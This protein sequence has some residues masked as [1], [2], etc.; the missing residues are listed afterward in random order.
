MSLKTEAKNVGV[1]LRAAP[2]PTGRVHIGNLRTFFYNYLYVKNQGGSFILRIEDTDQT[3]KVE[4]GTEGI[5]ETLKLYGIT[6]DEGPMSGGDYGPYVQ[7]QRV[8][9]YRKYAEELVEKG[10]AYYCFCSAD[11]LKKLREE[12]Q[13]S[14]LKPRYDRKCRNIDPQEAKKRVEAGESYVIRMKAPLEG[15]TAFEDVVYG[16]ITTPNKEVGD[17]ILLKSDGYPT[18]HLGVVV[19]DHLMEVSHIMRS[20]EWLPS[21]PKHIVMYE[22]FGWKPPIYVHVPVILNPE[23]PGKLS[24]RKGAWPAISYLRKGYLKEAVLNYFS[25]VGWAPSP[26]KAREDE[27]Y[28]VDDLI[29]LFDIKRIHK[30]GGRYNLEKLE[31]I[32]SKHIRRL[33]LKKLSDMIFSWVDDLVLEDFISDS[34]EETLDWEEELRAKVKKYAPKWKE[35]REYFEKILPLFHE[36]LMYL[37][38]LPDLMNFFYDK[39][40]DFDIEDLKSFG[41]GDRA[42]ALKELWEDISPMF[43]DKWDHDKW[44]QAVRDRADSLGWKHGQLFMLLRVAVTGRK[45]SPPLFDCLKLLG[46]DKCKNFISQAVEVLE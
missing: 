45:A 1:R 46:E 23:G 40:L 8:E 36:R 34:L 28:T 12:Q 21:T 3:R 39:E 30:A 14:G 32:N 37:G 38:E 19:D 20:S 7:S 10:A 2:S 4:K 26:E 29:E 13:E 16:K 25:L 27:I 22:A 11:R 9:L 6:F 31:A 44:E 18:Y 35:D 41:E 42:G 5:V 17:Q 15:V 33:S 43:K 24:K